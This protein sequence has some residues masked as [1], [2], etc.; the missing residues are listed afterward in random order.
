MKPHLLTLV[1]AVIAGVMLVTL[2]SFADTSPTPSAAPTRVAKAPAITAP[3]A[4]QPARPKASPS[5]VALP[6]GLKVAQLAYPVP[7]TSAASALLQAADDCASYG[8]W[9]GYRQYLRQ[10]ASSCPGTKEAGLALG[11]LADEYAS[12]GDGADADACR[13]QLAGYAD[14]EVQAFAVLARTAYPAQRAGQ[15]DLYQ[16]TLSGYAEK[17]KGTLSGGRAGLSLGDYYRFTA[18]DYPKAIA[19]YQGLASQAAGTLVGDEALV[20]LAETLDW[21]VPSQPEPAKV[22]FE[23]ALT[24]VRFPGL[25]VRCLVGLS[26][27]LLRTS[28]ESQAIRI[29]T[30]VITAYP[31]HPAV[32]HAYALRSTA[33]ERQGDWELAAGDARAFLA[34]PM[35]GTYNIA[36]AHSVVARDAF[37]K[38]DLA[39]A[40]AEYGTLAQLVEQE[41]HTAE[42][43]GEAQAGLAACALERGNLASALQLYQKAAGVELT[44]AK[45]AGYLFQAASVAQQLN[46]AVARAQIVAQMA[47]EVPG[48]NLTAQLAGDQALPTPGL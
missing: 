3:D 28:V 30:H 34:R 4:P 39:G 33:A 10:I 21:S 7:T 22:V 17:W 47:V 9:E 42:F 14:A 35:P 16:Q 6:R 23:S 27:L 40:E 26:D 1:V 13:G 29:L 15:N 44:A 45:K 43:R 11:L 37:R 46:N 2:T 36:R 20:S 8:D 18:E 32:A 24:S 31:S 48:S 12:L 19:T 25:Q 41:K 38:G 5:T